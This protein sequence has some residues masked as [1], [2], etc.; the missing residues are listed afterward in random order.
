MSQASVSRQLYYSYPWG[1]D[2]FITCLK[3][4]IANKIMLMNL[5]SPWSRPRLSVAD[6]V[7]CIHSALARWAA[8]F[9]RSFE[10]LRKKAPYLGARSF[11]VIEFVTNRIGICGFLLVVNSLISA[12][13]GTVSE[14]RRLIGL[15]LGHSSVSFNAL[16]RVIPCEYVDEPYDAKN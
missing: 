4:S 2:S 7:C 9:D 15:K 12:V 6:C 3:L 10:K 8:I 13:S 1:S 5:I 14:L 16:A 11:K